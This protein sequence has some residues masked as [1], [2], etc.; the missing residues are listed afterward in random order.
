MNLLRACYQIHFHL[1]FL[2]LV[3]IFLLLFRSRNPKRQKLSLFHFRQSFQLFYVYLKRNFRSKRTFSW[4]FPSL[5]LVRV[6]KQ[7][8]PISQIA[9]HLTFWHCE[10]SDVRQ[11]DSWLLTAKFRIFLLLTGKFLT[12]DFNLLTHWLSYFPCQVQNLTDVLALCY[13]A[14]LS[15]LFV[16]PWFFITNSLSVDFFAPSLRNTR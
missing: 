4:H 14:G 9:W 11:S 15:K 5:I 10:F 7:W 12:A 2:F 8:L 6:F 1:F 13:V 3:K 16:S